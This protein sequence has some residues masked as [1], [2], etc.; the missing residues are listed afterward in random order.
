MS[1]TPTTPPYRD[2][3]KSADERT[4]DLLARMT[5]EEKVA[6]MLCVWQKKAAMLV[7]E[8]GQFDAAKARQHF[9]HGRGLGRWDGRATRAED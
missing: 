8:L 2:P 7:D 4:A 3:A 1:A 5:L 6:Q 9:G